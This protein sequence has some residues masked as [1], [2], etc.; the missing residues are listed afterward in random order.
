MLYAPLR[1]AIY[2]DAEGT[3]WFTVD[4]PSTRFSS[5]GDPDITKVGFDLDHKLAVL[6]EYLEAPVP[7]AL[8]SRHA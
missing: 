3:T 7:E 4:Q 2:Q 1:T 5:F 8:T 6:L